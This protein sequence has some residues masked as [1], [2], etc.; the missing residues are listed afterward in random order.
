MRT[1]VNREKVYILGA[2]ESHVERS[3]A[4]YSP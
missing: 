2:A 4:G 3:L 1:V